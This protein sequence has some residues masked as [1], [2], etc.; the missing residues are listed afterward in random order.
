MD[1]AT[2]GKYL[3]AF[4]SLHRQVN[5]DH[6]P[7]PHKPVLLLAILDEVERGAYS[8]NLITVTPELAATFRVYWRAL[9][10][11]VHWQERMVY[12]FRHLLQ[13]GFWDLVKNG[14]SLTSK[15]LGDV[16]TLNQL[17]GPVDGARLP[18]DL[19]LLL[20]DPLAVNALRAHLFQTYF[21]TSEGNV[22]KAQPAS[23]LDYEAERL[24]AE[25][26]SKF[27]TK[28][29]REANDDLGYYV[30]HALFP[31]VVR[32]LYEDTC[33]V[34]GL[35]AR[36]DTGGGI[37]DAAH[38]M[39]FG[40]FHNDDPATASRFAKTTTGA[41]TPA[42]SA[43]PTPTKSSSRPAYK[44]V[45]SI[46]ANAPRRLPQPRLRPGGCRPRVAPRKQIPR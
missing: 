22:Q 16:F 26:Q 19:W 34:C 23:V 40:L 28:K 6:G 29:A 21:G 7:A 5:K 31:R 44:R 15:E 32:S 35:A 38:I 9:V 33:S 11:P 25:A 18:P 43:L 45:D 2:F 36:S 27:R 3:A 10:P 14:V 37:V 46:T 42:G 41:L 13:D 30:R 4:S 20:Q 17:S 12:P 24:K 1:R 39:P 8:E